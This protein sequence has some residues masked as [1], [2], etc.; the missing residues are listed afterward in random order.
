MSEQAV[1]FFTDIVHYFG[2]L[3]SIITD[4]GMQFIGK[5]FLSFCD[6]FHIR[7]D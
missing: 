5:K 1:L 3:N 2:V 4:K 7:M 6:D